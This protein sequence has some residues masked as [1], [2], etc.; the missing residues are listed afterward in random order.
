MIKALG[1]NPEP[2]PAPGKHGPVPGFSPDPSSCLPKTTPVPAH[3]NDRGRVQAKPVR[4][5]VEGAQS[6]ALRAAGAYTG[7]CRDGVE[8]AALRAARAYTGPRLPGAEARKHRSSGALAHAG[9]V[10]GQLTSWCRRS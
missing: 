7:S 4:V 6:A 3:T 1:R 2:P 5:T 8:T 9:Q 10:S